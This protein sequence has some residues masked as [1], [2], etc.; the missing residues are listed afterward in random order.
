MNEEKDLLLD[1][2]YD[3][4]QELDN[5]LPPWW[6]GMFY[7]SLI[8]APIY[9]YVYHGSDLGL[10]SAEEYEQEMETAKRIGSCSNSTQH[11]FN[12]PA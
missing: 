11:L 10:S 9:L 6:L 4:I 8:F 2:N 1:H 7:A 3:G 12:S 5:K